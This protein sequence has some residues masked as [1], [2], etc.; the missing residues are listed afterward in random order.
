MVLHRVAHRGY[1]AVA[2][3]NTLPALAAAILAGCTYV[4]FDVRTTADG[5]P[6]VF[7]D[8]TVDRTTDGSGHVW[9]LTLDEVS[10]L[11]AGSWFSP[12]YAGVRVP[13]LAEVLD[14][15][16]PDAAP[17]G[18]APDAARV[19]PPGPAAEVGL[20]LEIKPPATLDQVKTVLGMVAD[21]GLLDRTV[22]QSFDPEI[23]RLVR[24]ADPE[25][26]RGLLRVRFEADTV[27]L[28]VDLGVVCCN[29]S[30]DDVLGD[31]DTVA[32]LIGAGIDVMPWTANDSDRWPALVDAGV[33]GLITD[34]AGELTGWVEPAVSS[35][36]Q[37][38]PG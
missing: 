6:V 15:F 24:E 27:P 25:V 36:S 23:V 13:T 38:I 1:S 26:R 11:D 9:D 12:A 3:E 33:A 31:P 35:G 8:R 17:D 14:L 37:P 21:R 5:V 22:V 7:H 4:E 28:A 29:P 10:R 32:E 19:A 20:L 16:V 18:P 2:P 34:R 30:V